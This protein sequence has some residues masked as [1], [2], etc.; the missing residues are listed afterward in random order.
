MPI[1]RN[2]RSRLGVG[3]VLIPSGIGGLWERG[4]PVKK[5]GGLSGI[6]T[7][8]VAGFFLA[9]FFLTVV[10]GAQTYRAIVAGQARNNQARVLLSY[11]STCVRQN[12]TPGAVSI[13]EEDG[14]T[15]LS[16]ADGDT[17][18]ALRIYQEGDSL[19]EDYGEAG[20][21][22]YPDSAQTIG[23]TRVFRIEDLGGDTYAVVT[24]AGRVLFC[25]RS[26]ETTEGLT[27][28]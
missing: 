14:R 10:F 1:Q 15:V 20:A 21:K 27:D 16:I 4:A 18:Y 28:D 23:E 6:Y 7:M 13:L 17:G 11:L 22:L 9:G 2:G 25:L 3:V 19:L 24:D 26:R 12:D 5:D 8:A